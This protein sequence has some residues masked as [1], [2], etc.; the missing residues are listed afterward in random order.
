MSG[1]VTD[2]E[3]GDFVLPAL[4]MG[5]GAVLSATYSVGQAVESNRFWSDYE[6]KY[7]VRARYP[8]R[9]GQYDWL[10]S[11]GASMSDFGMSYYF[12]R[13]AYNRYRYKQ[14]RRW[15]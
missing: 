7:G 1:A 11:A 9:S 13:R 2:S 14:Y 3:G 12:G 8:W 10:S 15:H 6:K 4:L 5:A